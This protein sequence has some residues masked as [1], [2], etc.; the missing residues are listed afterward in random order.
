MLG[1]ALLRLLV[2]RQAARLLLV[3]LALGRHRHW[4]PLANANRAVLLC[5]RRFGVQRVRILCRDG[6]VGRTDDD[7]VD[8][9]T[10]QAVVDGKQRL[11]IGQ[12]AAGLRIVAGTIA[13]TAPTPPCSAPY[14][15]VR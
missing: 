14:T 12:C 13:V 9:V 3:Q 2:A 1:K 5:Y 7:L 6:L 11:R 10:G 8:R 15:S 4:T